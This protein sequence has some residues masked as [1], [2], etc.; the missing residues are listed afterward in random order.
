MSRNPE[1]QTLFKTLS[2]DT[3]F[4]KEKKKRRQKPTIMDRT[5]Y[6]ALARECVNVNNKRTSS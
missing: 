6:L 3:T 5:D 4:E 1:N 2:R